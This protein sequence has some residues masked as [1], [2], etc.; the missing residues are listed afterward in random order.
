MRVSSSG[1]TEPN[2]E[3]LSEVAAAS[4]ADIQ[5]ALDLLTPRSV[6]LDL[7]RIGQA[8]DG[9]YLLPK[10]L[11]GIT[12]CFSPGVNNFKKFEDEL[13][14]R[15]QI[16]SYM[17]DF[18]SDPDLFQTPLIP[19]LQFFE[20]KWLD[21]DGS[22]DAITLDEWVDRYTL[23]ERG[24]LLLQMDI[25]SAEYRNLAATETATLQRFRIIVLELHDLG[26]LDREWFLKGV[27]EPA[28]S[29]I[30]DGWL[31]VHAHANNCCGERALSTGAIVPSVLEVTFLRKDR[32]RESTAR[33]SIPHPH[34]DIN[35]SKF[36]PLHL[37]GDFLR[38]ADP[39]RS[40]LCAIQETQRWLV[41][42]SIQQ[43]EAA[44]QTRIEL[45]KAF[46]TVAWMV[47]RGLN[48]S[49]NIARGCPASQ[50]SLS[51][52]SV[53]DDAPRAVSGVYANGSY[54]FH[55]EFEENP[56]WMVDLRSE[57]AVEAIVVYNRTDACPDRSD[58]L[59]VLVSLDGNAWNTV[60][61]HAG[62]PPLGGITKT[63]STVA[64][65]PPLCI[66]CVGTRARYVKLQLAATTALHLDQIEVYAA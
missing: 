54:S 4:A 24:D 34:D 56:W 15:F 57:S 10:D 14:T 7:T 3:F 31:C 21:V 47:W 18:T 43:R 22:P 62:R 32:C 53:D 66:P 23:G 13:A 38:F 33:L 39:I 25:E 51:M 59:K 41:K 64:G 46:D 48:P 49:K 50:S 2:N 17:I 6:G 9:G 42:Q 20:K 35:V 40:T 58:S 45:G 16:P 60:Y 37:R 19:G 36:P 12:G 55:T 1:H 8:G 63:G 65:M 11:A 30:R 44:D 5:A 26:L 29:R 52:W 61:D 27:F 28:M